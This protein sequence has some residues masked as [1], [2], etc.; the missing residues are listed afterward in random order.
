MPD[1][2]SARWDADQQ[3]WVARTPPRSTGG[4][5]P[6]QLNLPT[7]ILV[8]LVILILATAVA[9][10][11]GIREDI[12]TK[13][14][15]TD[16]G[17]TSS[18]DGTGA[19][20]PDEHQDEADEHTVS[21]EPEVYE[22]REFDGFVLDIPQGW[23]SEAYGTHVL[24]FQED[25]THHIEVTNLHN[26]YPSPWSA[27]QSLEA[28]LRVEHEHQDYKVHDNG[29]RELTQP[30]AMELNY[31]YSNDTF[32]ERNVYMRVLSGEDGRIYV[33][34]AT[35]PREHGEL[36]QQHYERA[37]ETFSLTG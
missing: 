2:K 20:Q 5:L 16:M 4:R 8:P 19:T 24:F 15:T 29:P 3:A 10:A 32:D 27:M 31:G 36:N 13:N 22:P 11:V 25:R 26:D 33:I 34:A 37:V 1:S 18:K 35:G 17:K 28:A 21:D 14:T 6:N 23:Q 12:A 30:P 9:A 7:L